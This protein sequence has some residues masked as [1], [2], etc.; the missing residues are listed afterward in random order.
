MVDEDGE[1]Q[2]KDLRDGIQKVW[3]NQIEK[4]RPKNQQEQVGFGVSE[5]QNPILTKLICKTDQNGLGRI[6]SV[7]FFWVDQVFEQL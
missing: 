7:S 4:S 3:V 2:Q 6:R 5:L 1:G